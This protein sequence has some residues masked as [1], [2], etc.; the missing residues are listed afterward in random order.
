VIEKPR[1]VRGMLK[2]AG[3]YL[4]DLCVF[5]TLRRTPR[6]AL[7]DEYEFTDAVQVMIDGGNPVRPATVVLDDYNL[8][9]PGDLLLCNL[10]R[11]TQ[12]CRPA[13]RAQLR[14]ASHAQVRNSVIGANV[15]VE[16]PIAI[17]N[18]L[19]FEGTRVR[20]HESLNEVIVTPK[21]HV[22]C[23]RFIAADAPGSDARRVA[24]GVR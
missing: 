3:M 1:Q 13:A 19:I 20:G 14:A 9:N 22:D 21:L 4:F 8:S 17:A 11:S 16:H 10:A 6:T 18:S 5:D 7:R 24:A 12:S 15:T 2:G 23:T